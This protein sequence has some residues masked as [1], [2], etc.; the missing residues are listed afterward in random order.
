[1]NQQIAQYILTL[2]NRANISGVEA[3]NT[4]AAKQWLQSIAKGQ[5][6]VSEPAKPDALPELTK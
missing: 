1:M 6:V 4:V 5:L 3:E 2:V